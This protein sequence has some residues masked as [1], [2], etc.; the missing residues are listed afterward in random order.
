MKDVSDYAPRARRAGRHLIELPMP[1][2]PSTVARDDPRLTDRSWPKNT[3][4]PGNMLKWTPEERWA[5]EMRS[6]LTTRVGRYWRGIDCTGTIG[7]P[8]A[9]GIRW[10]CFGRRDPRIDRIYR[11][12]G[13]FTVATVGWAIG[14]NRIRLGRFLML[15][16]EWVVGYVR[17]ISPQKDKE[18]RYPWLDG[19]KMLDLAAAVAAMGIKIKPVQEDPDHLF[20]VATK[21]AAYRAGLGRP[22]QRSREPTKPT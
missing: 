8:L 16:P 9:P 21:V 3:Y 20:T 1:P 10:Y 7:P 2:W 5:L 19:R 18:V 6:Y 15:H 11:M 12:R 14:V 17:Q 4:G 22:P 13:K